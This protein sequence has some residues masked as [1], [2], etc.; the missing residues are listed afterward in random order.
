LKPLDRLF[1]QQPRPGKNEMRASTRGMFLSGLVYPGLGQMLS[2][3]VASGVAFALGT[4]AGLIVLLYCLMQR[5]F[6]AMDQ[7]L[8]LLADNALDMQTLQELLGRSSSDG[9]GLES[10][11]LIGV[12]G[13]W[14][15]A[16]A[17]AYFVGRKID[18]QSRSTR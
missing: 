5:V 2:G 14:L 17:H 16:V 4:T 3:H 7:I 18:L 1:Q 10:I 8:P 6:K 13:C 15:A 12:V 9:W 11:C